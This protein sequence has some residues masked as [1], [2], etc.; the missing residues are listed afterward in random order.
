MVNHA[1]SAVCNCFGETPCSHAIRRFASFISGK[2]I[3]QRVLTIARPKTAERCV[4]TGK[5][6]GCRMRDE[7]YVSPRRPQSERA[8]TK[9]DSSEPSSRPLQIC[10]ISRRRL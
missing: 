7:E 3:P 1:N 5:D 9:Q 4:M 2:D 8:N 6:K 10:P